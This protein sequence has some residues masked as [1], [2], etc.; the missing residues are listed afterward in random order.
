MNDDRLVACLAKY[1]DSQETIQAARK[2]IVGLAVAGRLDDRSASQ[3]ADT[4]GEFIGGSGH[5]S[6]TTGAKAKGLES[7]FETTDLPHP[8]LTPDRFVRLGDIAKIEKGKTGIKQAR[9]GPY[10]LV[11]TASD[12]GSCDHYDFDG[13]SAIVPLVSSTGHGKASLHR[14]HYQEGKFALGSILAAAFPKSPERISARFLFEYLSAFKEELLVSQMIGTANVSLTVKKI[15]EVPV[16]IVSRM[17]QRAVDELM[18]LCDTLEAEREKREATRDRLTTASLS[19]LTATDINEKQFKAHA[20]FAIKVLPELT[21]RPDQIEVLRQTILDLAVRGKLV[22]Q[23]PNDEPVGFVEYEVKDRRK[24]DSGRKAPPPFR[25]P[26]NWTWRHL[27]SVARQVTDGEHATPPRIAQEE[28]PL[29]TAK[30]V[31]EGYMDYSQTDWV[32]RETAEKAWRRC[33]PVVGDILLVCVG[34]TTG[35][36]T[37]LRRPKEMVLVRSVALI[38]PNEEVASDYLEWAIRSQLVQSQIWLSVKATAQ[39]CL[40]INRIQSLLVPVPPRAEQHR[41]VKKIEELTR[42]CNELERTGESIQSIRSR[43][44]DALINEVFTNDV[45]ATA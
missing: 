31:R 22:E 13:A 7:K 24:A 5:P 16:P 29:V 9:S 19:R 6:H 4:L 15:S 35:R 40:Y 43:L 21:T 37:T 33:R 30:N 2:A 34:A 36:V 3:F 27:G 32:S 25:A 38:R 8:S 28:I 39:P 44:F 20:D 23:D 17:A 42:A 14:L 1:A 10:P 45:H 18:A 26:M 11:V 12:R 41:I